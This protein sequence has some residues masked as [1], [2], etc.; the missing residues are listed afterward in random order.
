MSGASASP[1]VPGGRD[2]VA[3]RAAWERQQEAHEPLR[4]ERFRTMLE[5]VELIAP[6]PRRILDL[7]C[8]TGA[9]A[10]RAHERF[11]EAE[12][13]GVDLDPILLLL[14]RE[15]FA[16]EDR[17]RFVTADLREPDWASALG[18]GPFDAVLTATALHWLQEPVL[19]RV[20]AD[21]GA[22]LRPGGVFLNADHVAI[23]DPVLHDV[24]ATTHL[25][26]KRRAFDAGQESYDG[27]WERAEREPAL[28][29]L[30]EERTR[31]FE[32]W[33]DELAL[34]PQWH[35]S[36]L[37]GAG[38]SSADVVWRWGNDALVAAIR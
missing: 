26:H 5:Y 12:V 34:T 25:E 28:R 1:P 31:R 6:A 21:V 19:R 16:A 29:P 23:A 18:A 3:W 17:V 38:F 27:W 24:A 9:I 10:E 15:A 20:Y 8:G 2:V 4:E 35:E 33:D 14:A 37:R 7:A 36:T 13:V 22:L 11:S 32:G 30:V